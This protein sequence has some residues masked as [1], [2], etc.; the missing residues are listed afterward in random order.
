MLTLALDTSNTPLS[1]AVIQ[2][3]QPLALI[4][5]AKAR[6]HSATL[7]PAI[8]QA[9]NFAAVKLT[10]IDQFI[11]AAGPGSYTG[12]RIAITTA[13]MLAWT[14]KKPL[15]QVSSL[16]A[17]TTT[18]RSVM[19]APLLVPLIDARRNCFFAGFYQWRENGELQQRQADQYLAAEQIVASVDRLRAPNQTIVI[20]GQLTVEQQQWW[21]QAWPQAQVTI[22]TGLAT[23]PVATEFG[24]LVTAKQLVTDLDHFAPNYLRPTEAE[25]N[26]LK[27]HPGEAH[28]N[29]VEQ[30]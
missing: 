13:K 23:M 5:T 3:Q 21:R 8:D 2:D 25:A 16:A 7:M 6:N 18:W 14:L 17:L 20:N 9:L 19:P 4:Q 22:A 26:W 11:V 10:D 24:R 1:V 28:E 29:F 30:V 27:E 12:V 15:Y